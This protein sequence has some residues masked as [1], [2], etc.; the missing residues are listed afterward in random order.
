MEEETIRRIRAARGYAG[1]SQPALAD[2]LGMSQDTLKRIE[3]KHRDLKGYELDGFI[4]A[5]AEATDLP[6]E[7]F[8]A[9][10]FSA[11]TTASQAGGTDAL[12]AKLDSLGRHLEE[13]LVI[14][15]VVPDRYIREAH[16]RMA[17]EG[18]GDF[19]EADDLAAPI[20]ELDAEL[21]RER[22]RPKGAETGDAQDRPATR[23]G[24]RA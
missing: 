21:E 22:S 1:L 7:F 9:P 13:L 5:V 4:R 11:L 24:R 20:A 8:T 12:A 16:E 14:Y 17:R 3:L 19:R 10:D 6:V 23:P 2:R 15:E 18:K